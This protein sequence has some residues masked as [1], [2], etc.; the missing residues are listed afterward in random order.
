MIF[1]DVLHSLAENNLEEQLKIDLNFHNQEND[2]ILM[3]IIAVLMIQNEKYQTAKLRA[4]ETHHTLAV[5][6]I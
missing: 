3:A 5:L 1:F 6:N 2:S 4:I